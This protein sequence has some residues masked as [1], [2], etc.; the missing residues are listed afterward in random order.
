MQLHADSAHPH[1]KQSGCEST[2]KCSPQGRS[3]QR[4][5]ASL[6]VG[7]D[8][9]WPWPKEPVTSRL[10]LYHL[11][12]PS[13]QLLRL[14]HPDHLTLSSHYPS[15]PVTL[16]FIHSSS[17]RQKHSSSPR[18]SRP[19]SKDRSLAIP[20]RETHL[21]WALHLE[22]TQMSFYYSVKC[23]GRQWVFLGV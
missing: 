5:G 21:Q 7:E 17:C 8:G 1:D 14:W 12:R 22:G 9:R 4:G 10:T 18:Q 13:P 3:T 2:R 11:V 23:P 20:A 19:E 6:C 16:T 15:L